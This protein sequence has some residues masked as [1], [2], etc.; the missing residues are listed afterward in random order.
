M[1]EVVTI[2]LKFPQSQ[3]NLQ[4]LTIPVTFKQ[5]NLDL[6]SLWYPKEEVM[7]F[8]CRFQMSL[9][10]SMWRAVEVSAWGAGSVARKV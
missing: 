10:F 6:T 4:I 7:L 3:A 2:V 9:F 5:V 1:A 8:H